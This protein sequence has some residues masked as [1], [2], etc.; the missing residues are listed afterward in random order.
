MVKRFRRCE[1]LGASKDAHQEQLIRMRDGVSKISSDNTCLWCLRRR[2]QTSFRCKHSVCHAC[3]RIFH[4]AD[5]LDTEAVP[6]EYCLI[7]GALTHGAAIR[8]PPATAKIR[9]LS[10]DGGGMRGIGEIEML[11]ALEWS[12]GL[13]YPI[14]RHFDVCLATSCGESAS[15]C[16]KLGINSNR[17]WDHVEA[18]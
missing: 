9:V 16:N 5:V 13:P 14:I 1:A 6:V 15:S 11:M 12:I 8:E 3:V 17:C 10:L 18:L 4:S 2:P 7:C